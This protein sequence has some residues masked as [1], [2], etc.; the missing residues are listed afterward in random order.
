LSC[1]PRTLDDLESKLVAN[2]LLG[3]LDALA[4]GL[5]EVLL[6]T[7]NQKCVHWHSP[8]TGLSALFILNHMA[9]C[10]CRKG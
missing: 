9:V 3:V 6:A 10:S 4:Q 2:H 1:T 8:K 5:D 7:F